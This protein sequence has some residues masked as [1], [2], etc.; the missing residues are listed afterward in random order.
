MAAGKKLYLS[1]KLLSEIKI[2]MI[3]IIKLNNNWK[4]NKQSGRKTTITTE[5]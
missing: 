3:I 2:I 4:T 1:Y 5:N